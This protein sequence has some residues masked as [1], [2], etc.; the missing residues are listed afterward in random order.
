MKKEALGIEI[1]EVVKVTYEIEDNS[2]LMPSRVIEE[3]WTLDKKKIGTI[4]PLDNYRAI[5]ESVNSEA[6][7]ATNSKEIK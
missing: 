4:D 2:T 5:E 6:S 3:Y 7:I 1:I